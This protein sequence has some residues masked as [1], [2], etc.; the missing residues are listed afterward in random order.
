VVGNTDISRHSVLIKI[1]GEELGKEE[2]EREPDNIVRD[3][4]SLPLI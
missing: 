3:A 2:L 4:T 1:I